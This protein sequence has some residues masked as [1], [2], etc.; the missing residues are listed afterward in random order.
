MPTDE[1]ESTE[2]LIA[3]PPEL[4]ERLESAAGSR[5]PLDNTLGVNDIILEAVDEH[6]TRLERPLKIGRDGRPERSGTLFQYLF[7][8]DAE[9]AFERLSEGVIAT[10][11]NADALLED[12]S[13]LTEAK[14]YERAEFLIATAQEEM[15][16]AYI[17]LDMCRVDLARHQHV[18]RK[19]MP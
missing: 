18:L 5:A 4:S 2:Y 1:K 7:S 11:D 6:L 13:V 16:K 8:G 12:A 3:L 14:R 17:L 15:G 19:A 9:M 10:L